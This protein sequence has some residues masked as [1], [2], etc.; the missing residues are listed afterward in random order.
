MPWSVL[1]AT[2]L[3]GRRMSLLINDNDQANSS[4]RGG[5]KGYLQWF[6]GIGNVKDPR[7]YG[8]IRMLPA[9]THAGASAGADTE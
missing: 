1:G 6:D 7:R 2:T 5:R 3:E 4:Y 8:P 9:A